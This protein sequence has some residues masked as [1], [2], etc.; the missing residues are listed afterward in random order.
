[1]KYMLETQGP[2]D[3]VLGFHNSILESKGTKDMLRRAQRAKIKNILYTSDGGEVENPVLTNRSKSSKLD[4][5]VTMD[6]F[7]NF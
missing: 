4:K 5:T 2:F 3:I 1:N 7:F 6:H